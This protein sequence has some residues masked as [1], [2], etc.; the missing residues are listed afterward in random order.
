MFVCEIS[1]L[2]K[3]G[4]SEKWVG[5]GRQHYSK[6]EIL[7]NYKDSSLLQT[8]IDYTRKKFYDPVKHSWSKFTHSFCKLGRFITGYYNSQHSKM[9]LL[10]KRMC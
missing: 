10:N 8:L 1:S 4:A 9:V 6:L 3:S 7:A 2:P 5:S